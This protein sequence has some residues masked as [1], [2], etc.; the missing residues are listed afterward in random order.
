MATPKSSGQAHPRPKISIFLPT[1]AR[2]ES[3]HLQ[4]AIASVE[5]QTFAEWELLCVD[6]GSVDGTREFLTERSQS[7]A[8]IR[9][10]RL[11][12]NY[13]LPAFTLAKAWPLARGDCLAW[14]F[15]DC[16][17]A[18][19][20]L[21]T[22]SSALAAR[23]EAAMVYAKALA[24]LPEGA[25][26]TIG[27]PLDLENLFQGENVIPNVCVL[28]RREVI[29]TIGW[30][31][32]HVLLKRLC[33]WDLWQRIARNY[34]IVF[35]DQ[36]L[37]IENG[38]RLPDSIG[39]RF[40]WNKSL[41]SRYSRTD[42][43]ARL[44]PDR[45]SSE[46][47]FREDIGFA[48]SPDDLE[49]LRYILLEHAHHTAD[50]VRALGLAQSLAE[51]APVARLLDQFRAVSGR[52][53]DEAGVLFCA[54]T[55]LL[56]RRIGE[57]T[58]TTVE[59]ESDT[60]KWLAIA[61]DRLDLI[62]QREAEAGRWLAVAD[63]RLGLIEKLST[64]R[65]MLTA[66]LQEKQTIADERLT[67]V[68][69]MAAR[70]AKSMELVEDRSSELAAARARIAATTQALQEIQTESAGLAG[71]VQEQTHALNALHGTLDT[72]QSEAVARELTVK[73]ALGTLA[74]MQEQ[75]AVGERALAAL[76]VDLAQGTLRERDLLDR[77][78]MQETLV[79]ALHDRLAAQQGILD[80]VIGRCAVYWHRLRKPR[81]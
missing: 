53:A 24:E 10:L 9:H 68:D 69:S 35:V 65:A 56:Q 60:R 4:R 16:E 20:H 78:A 48:L 30:Y 76:R 39:R 19:S 25:S 22:L 23:P 42:R 1:A 51:S 14:L 29:G 6:D 71:M 73:E 34:P 70:L 61:D 13:G 18:D 17:F 62:K 55:A 47:C 79:A 33:D 74:R 5:R 28:L 3:G 46:D 41:V 27:G 32:P 44:H 77:A 11:D 36:C 38:R 49:S 75:L 37:A 59:W 64:D 58:A 50:R 54:S 63:E 31:D 21:A 26:F 45:L 52:E 67:L 12:R 66:S 7:D 8:R 43:N 80:T 57:E 40:S 15:D 2:F 81:Q 72:L